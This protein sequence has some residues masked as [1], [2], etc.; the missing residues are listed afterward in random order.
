MWYFSDSHIG[1]FMSAAAFMF[2]HGEATR[3]QWTPPLRETF[4]YPLFLAQIV[5]IT[6]ILKHGTNLFVYLL[7]MFLNVCFLLSWQ[8]G[9]RVVFVG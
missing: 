2:N 3:V 8:V 9:V 6:Y 5:T 1:G 4:G 7:S